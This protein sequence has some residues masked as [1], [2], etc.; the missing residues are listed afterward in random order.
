MD[1]EASARRQKDRTPWQKASPRLKVTNGGEMKMKNARRD[2]FR[3]QKEFAVKWSQRHD[4]GTRAQ[5][6]RMKCDV[7]NGPPRPA[8][9]ASRFL[10]R[11]RGTK[12]F[13]C[14][15]EAETHSHTRTGEP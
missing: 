6:E 9:A 11:R 4:K 5:S 1:A 2:E 12:R 8:G 10:R 3:L 7:M 15:V 14:A 13:Q